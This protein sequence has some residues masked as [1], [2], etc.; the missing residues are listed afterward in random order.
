MQVE[1]EGREGVWDDLLGR[2]EEAEA[3]CKDLGPWDSF[4][5]FGSLMLKREICSGKS[6]CQAHWDRPRR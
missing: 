4:Q 1:R 3:V 2:L 5:L 6:S